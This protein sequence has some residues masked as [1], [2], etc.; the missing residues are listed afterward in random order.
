MVSCASDCTLLTTD[1][2]VSVLWV[3][4]NSSDAY[5]LQT[6]LPLGGCRCGCK[7]VQG[8]VDGSIVKS[9]IA[10]C[11]GELSLMS[12]ML[13]VGGG[14]VGGKEVPPGRVQADQ[15][16][17]KVPKPSLTFLSKDQS[18]ASLSSKVQ[19]PSIKKC[20][21][22][23]LSLQLDNGGGSSHTGVERR[24]GRRFSLKVRER[25]IVV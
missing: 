3:H 14:D 2:S 21:L 22:Y 23:D 19:P 15:G 10:V 4:S 20:N 18:V 25:A 24:G 6:S 13:S 5:T 8:G 1:C 11:S 16:V 9:T 7:E 17:G 12:S